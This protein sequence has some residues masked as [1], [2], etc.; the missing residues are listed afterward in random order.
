MASAGSAQ[1]EARGGEN[2]KVVVDGNVVPDYAKVQGESSCG[3]EPIRESAE[4][5]TLG[6][7]D[8]CPARRRY[9]V[10]SDY[11]LDWTRECESL[12]LDIAGNPNRHLSSMDFHLLIS[13]EV[14][15]RLPWRHKKAR[16]LCETRTLLSD[17][18]NSATMK[19]LVQKERQTRRS[20]LN[21]SSGLEV[22]MDSTASSFLVQIN[23]TA[24]RVTEITS[25][26]L[27]CVLCVA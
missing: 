16:A 6:V 22:G 25:L 8:R 19:R 13:T 4:E 17:I 1:I 10:D 9:R 12:L 7:F 15:S 26:I 20:T 21:M 27:G 14:G 18:G 3:R 11:D 24:T 2:W 23:G 5:L